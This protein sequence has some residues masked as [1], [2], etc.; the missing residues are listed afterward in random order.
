[1]MV[2]DRVCVCGGGGLD[3][4]PSLKCGEVINCPWCHHWISA[5]THNKQLNVHVCFK[6]ETGVIDTIGFICFHNTS[7]FSYTCKHDK[8]YTTHTHIT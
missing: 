3:P 1:M 6:I 7:I 2:E 5:G 4:L 8:A